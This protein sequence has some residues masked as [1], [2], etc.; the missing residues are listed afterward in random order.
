MSLQILLYVFLWVSPR[1]NHENL[2]QVSS[3]TSAR[4]SLLSL[5]FAPHCNLALRAQSC[6]KNWDDGLTRLPRPSRR[7]KSRGE[8]WERLMD[9][10]W[11]RTNYQQWSV[12]GV[13]RPFVGYVM[14]FS[15]GFGDHT[16][17]LHLR[18]VYFQRPA[19]F[20]R[21]FS[22]KLNSHS[23]STGTTRG[24]NGSVSF[25]TTAHWMKE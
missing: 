7:N 19:H 25:C 14:I 6:L 13:I 2:S 22:R 15:G 5:Q 16:T 11:R 20:Q 24:S 12:E 10:R 3:S 1:R 23:W 18:L 4:H 17:E 9:A 8:E 21:I